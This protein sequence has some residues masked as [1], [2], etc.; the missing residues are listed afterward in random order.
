MDKE[1]LLEMLSKKPLPE[2]ERDIRADLMV[3][4]EFYRDHVLG[5]QEPQIRYAVGSLLKRLG[6]KK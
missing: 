5:K 2:V 4:L 1:A 6:E 3:Q